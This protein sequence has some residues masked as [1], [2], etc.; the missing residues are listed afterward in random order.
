MAQTALI[1]GA[2]S[3][4]GL[5]FSNIF[6]RRGCDLVLVARN[7]EKLLA[8]QK[9]LS[10]KYGVRVEVLVCDMSKERAG[11]VLFAETSARGIAVD[12]LVNNAGFGDFGAF[13]HCDAR[14]QQDMI[15]VNI[16][17]LT[18]LTRCFLEPM[19]CRG[20]GKI[21]NVASIAAFQPGPTMAVYY[22]SKA[23]V[24]SFTEALSVELQ[25]SGVSV[26]ALCPGPT[27]TGFEKNAA[28]GN[29]GLFQNLKVAT[30]RDVAEYGVHALEKGKVIAIPGAMNRLIVTASKF[31]P[32]ALVRRCVYRIQKEK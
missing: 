3:G 17:A 21:L 2:S 7:E 31:A 6:A 5:E 13:A 26:T 14:K 30:A 18:Q 20:C 12:I 24:L 32:R 19:V 4:L 15:A 10:Q 22:A 28:L 1:T 8:Q 16:A 25:G 9:E 27:T 23:F 29:S 11:D